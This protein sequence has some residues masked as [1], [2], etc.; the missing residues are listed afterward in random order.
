MNLNII[1]GYVTTRVQSR[2]KYGRVKD[3]KNY[4]FES[5]ITE[6]GKPNV[7]EQGK[8]YLG[9][10]HSTTRRQNGYVLVGLG[11]AIRYAISANDTLDKALT[12][13]KIKDLRKK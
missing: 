3:E 6:S 8:M 2:V 4:G 12:E 10:E 7:V 1:K 13:Q 5:R 11:D 9:L